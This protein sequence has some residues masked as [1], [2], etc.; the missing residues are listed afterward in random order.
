M[1]WETEINPVKVM[2]TSLFRV[3]EFGTR[4]FSQSGFVPEKYGAR[5]ISISTSTYSKILKL[6]LLLNLVLP[7]SLKVC[8]CALGIHPYMREF[9]TTKVSHDRISHKNR[10]NA[11]Q[12]WYEKMMFWQ[13][14]MAW[15]K[16]CR[17]GH[18]E[19]QKQMHLLR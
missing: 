14:T 16:R 18:Y 7:N 13:I 6:L 3:D 10:F 1:W 12:I 19:L 4:L 15:W 9:G 11:F 8:I 17:R 2:R 5:Q